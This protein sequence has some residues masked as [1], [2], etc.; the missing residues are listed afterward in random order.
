MNF[1]R[2]LSTFVSISDMVKMCGARPVAMETSA[3]NNYIVDS[4]TL[5]DTL[6]K[7]PKTK[8]IILCNPSNPTGTE[9]A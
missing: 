7:H 2:E 8:A 4:M 3:D 6:N 9:S 1:M 5:R